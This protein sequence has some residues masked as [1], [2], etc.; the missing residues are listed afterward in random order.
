MEIIWKDYE[1][2]TFISFIANIAT[3]AT[4]AIRV[5]VGVFLAVS[6]KI[7][8]I[9]SNISFSFY[10][11]FIFKVCRFSDLHIYTL[12]FAIQNRTKNA[13]ELVG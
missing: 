11:C 3:M 7:S 9:E 6:S 2:S 10:K 5:P 4:I 8:M 12:L 1:P 13:S